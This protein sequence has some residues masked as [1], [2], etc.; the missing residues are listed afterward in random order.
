MKNLLKATIATCFFLFT[1]STTTLLFAQTKANIFD[2]S[3]EITWLGLDFSQTKFI[4]AASNFGDAG[5]VT[6][7]SFKNKYAQGWNHLFI[8]EMKKYDVAAAVHRTGVKYAIDVTEK[9]NS[10]LKKDFFSNNPGDYKSI[11]EAKIN[12]AVKGYDFQGNT[13]I[14]MIYFVE[15][16][17]KGQKAAGAWVTFVDM[18]SHTV[19]FTKYMEGKS[20]GFGFKNYWAAA[21]LDILKDVKKQFKGW[22]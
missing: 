9:A 18:K 15:G 1:A 20:G 10:N 12:A 3:T 19:L 4:G 6:N 17:S 22:K 7:E 14:G 8:D 13:G 5:E 21:F 16:M 2:G 11:D